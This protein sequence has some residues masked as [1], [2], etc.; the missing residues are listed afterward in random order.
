MVDAGDSRAVTGDDPGSDDLTRRPGATAVVLTYRRPRLATQVVRML[1]DDEGFSPEEVVLVINGEGGLDDEDLEQRLDVLH[2]PRNVGPAGGFAAGLT[3]AAS[4]HSAE[5][6]YLCEDDVGLFDLPVPRVADVLARLGSRGHSDAAAIVAYGRRL[7]ERT[8]LTYPVLVEDST[9]DFERVDVA[10]WGATL[11]SR[12]VVDAG[13]LPDS[14]LFFGYEDFDFFLK[15]RN[16]GLPVLLDTRA[17][18][19]LQEVVFFEAREEKLGSDRPLDESEP[20]RQYY[21]AR[22]FFHLARR[23]GSWS[24]LAWHWLKSLR[25][26]QLLD[27]GGRRAYLEGLWQGLRGRTGVNNDF[28]RQVGE[29]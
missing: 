19:A 8:G 15:M 1:I 2:L 18:K 6:I 14:D 17:S 3:R 29:L 16:K 24:W 9:A 26:L 27:W 13:I 12:S 5:W 4:D 11:V 28:V 7:D 22:N 23:H 20:W 10:A 25:R 21:V